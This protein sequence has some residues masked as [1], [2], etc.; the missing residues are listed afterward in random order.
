VELVVV[1]P[2]HRRWDLLPGA[3]AASAPHPVIVVDDAPPDL[4]HADPEGATVVRTTGSLGF[5]RAVNAGLRAAEA[6]GATHA[7]LLND[8]AAPAP[9]CIAQLCAAWDTGVGAVGPLLVDEAGQI[10]SAGAR[11]SWWGRVRLAQQAPAGTVDVDALSG[12]CLLV[13]ASARLDE[14][15]THGFEDFALCRSLRASGRRVLLVG[16]AQCVHRGGATLGRRSRAAQRHAV[17]GHLR[18]L[19]R[20]RFLPVV[21]GLALAQVAREGGPAERVVGVADGVRDWWSGRR[22][23]GLA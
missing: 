14:G 9:G 6:Q 8:D 5:A 13:S 12:A 22:R 23:G 18:L 4:E 21:V 16:G 11:L 3:I 15:F 1:I 19:G 20:R 7:L 10:E 17:S 2:C